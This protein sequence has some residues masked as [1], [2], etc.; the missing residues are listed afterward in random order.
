M[1]FWNCSLYIYQAY[2]YN[3]QQLFDWVVE[4]V[5][6][7]NNKNEWHKSTHNISKQSHDKTTKIDVRPAKT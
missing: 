5:L 1:T 6:K 4:P 2:L 7:K 3:A